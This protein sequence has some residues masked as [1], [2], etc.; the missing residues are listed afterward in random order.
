MF[1]GDPATTLLLRAQTSLVG[2]DQ[3]L[4]HIAR[5]LREPAT[6]LLTLS[7][8]PGVGKTRLAMELLLR[9][10]HTGDAIY[11]DLADALTAEAIKG[12]VAR[13]LNLAL[14]GAVGP[15]EHL[16]VLGA[17]L[18]SRG[19]ALL[20]FDNVDVA[21]DAAR[22]LIAELLV[23]APDATVMVAS[24]ARLSLAIERVVELNPLPTQ[25]SAGREA[26]AVELFLERA[27]DAC[28]M[29]PVDEATRDD[30]Y[31]IVEALD[32]L[33]LAIELAAARTSLLS[34]RELRERMNAPLGLLEGPDR[35]LRA[36]IDASWRLLKERERAALRV[37]AAFRGQF[38]PA[39]AEAAFRALGIEDG[40]AQLQRLRE[41]SL[42][43]VVEIDDGERALRLYESIRAFA[44]EASDEGT[45]KKA[46]RA[47]GLSC[48]SLASQCL[49]DA[50]G[51]QSHVAVR[52]LR[53]EEHNLQAFAEGVDESAD[54]EVLSSAASVVG[55]LLHLR[56]ELGPGHAFVNVVLRLAGIV[57][58]RQDALD[59]RKVVAFYLRAA[60][61]VA[62]LGE[63]EHAERLFA[64][65]A[66]RAKAIGDARIEGLALVARARASRVRR[67]MSAAASSALEEA[68]RLGERTGDHVVLCLAEK[69]VADDCQA[70]FDTKAGLAAAERAILHAGR[71]NDPRLEARA[72]L[73][74]AVLIADTCDWSLAHRLAMDVRSRSGPLDDQRT[75]GFAS[76]IAGGAALELHRR[77]EADGLFSDAML[78]ARRLGIFRLLGYAKVFYGAS[79]C[80][81]RDVRGAQ[82]AFADAVDAF[83]V[84]GEPVR[85]SS[86]RTAL[87]VATALL[88]RLDEAERIVEPIRAKAT[89]AQL[90]MIDT[91]A[92]GLSAVRAGQELERGR[93]ARAFALLAEARHQLAV[94]RENFGELVR[95]HRLPSFVLR[96]SLRFSDNVVSAFAPPDGSLGFHEDRKQLRLPDGTVESFAEKPMLWRL[97]CALAEVHTHSPGTYVLRSTLVDEVWPEEKMSPRAAIN[98]LSV[99][100]HK[101]KK[102]GLAPFL[103]STTEGL[104]IRPGIHVVW[105]RAFVPVERTQ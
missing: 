15:A 88:G 57:A 78:V 61:L 11:C 69:I 77:G 13:S 72:K 20:L 65:A 79:L 56:E 62:R 73:S 95:R 31:A 90:S 28:G 89:P 12:A 94:T 103:E 97:A 92:I 21:M 2:R 47:V 75:F 59:A 71:C 85:I 27:R 1:G 22:V 68:I 80:E 104:R 39:L 32:G 58:Q 100:I 9:E 86:A 82:S 102:H 63:V 16:R 25:K 26:P 30:V 14:E 43:K 50:Y 45:S 24:R 38:T 4:E 74:Q 96:L 34:P 91:I 87:G 35:S 19:N 101:L 18:S 70:R 36:T 29:D 98:R 99:A 67:G 23:L 52:R 17:A 93:E 37:C 49:D 40:L 3:E 83:E 6:R 53:A 54:D 44:I 84:L 42:L 46:L 7:G 48:D 5:L 66:A 8:P 33:P 60:P 51:P 105:A 64:H 81:Q 41:R 55:A 76:V 10:P